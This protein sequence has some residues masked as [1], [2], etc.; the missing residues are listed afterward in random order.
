MGLEDFITKYEHKPVQENDNNVQNSQ[1]VSVCVQTYQ[2]VSFIEQCLDGI[3]SQETNFSFEILLGEDASTDGTREICIEYAKKYPNKIRLFLHHRENNIKIN[4]SPSGRFNFLF[5]LYSARGKYIAIC[6]GDDYWIDRRKLQKQVDFLE[7]NLDYGLVYTKT[8]VFDQNQNKLVSRKSPT[9]MHPKGI[10]YYNPIPTVTILFKTGL[11]RRFLKEEAEKINSWPM[12]DYSMG[13]WIYYNSKIHYLKEIT[14]VYRVLESSVSHFKN[15]NKRMDFM[16]SSFEMTK[17]F[18]SK[19]LPSKEYDNFLEF[20]YLSL[21]KASL[22]YKT[23]RY[24]KYH[25]LLKDMK[26]KDFT[27]ALF[28]FAF[29]NLKLRKLYTFYQN[30]KN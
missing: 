7:T 29:E 25:G 1:L 18:A 6:E 26:N 27:T 20:K 28:I 9:K 30:L 2:H 15:G 23:S 11:M 5:N 3:L 22:L 21:Y 12:K 16:E 17:Y 19:Y 10:L 4:G 24:K 13:I 14:S 8:M